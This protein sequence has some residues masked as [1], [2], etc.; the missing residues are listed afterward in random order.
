VAPPSPAAN[1]KK[2]HVSEPPQDSCETTQQPGFRP[3]H[4][5]F[6]LL[7]AY[8]QTFQEG[9]NPTDAV[10]AKRLGVRRET[11]SRWRRRNARLRAWLYEA[12]GERASELR[13]FVDRRV[14]QLAISGS[15]DHMKLFYQFVAKVG[16][17]VA[18]GEELSSDSQ[19]PSNAGVIINVLTP[20]PEMYA[21]QF[22][23]LPGPPT[24]G[25][26]A[27]PAALPPASNIPV[28]SVKVPV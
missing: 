21:P 23:Q 13:A 14:T 16:L 15:P 22:N 20:R 10:I 8:E 1:H 6:R 5:H 19:V 4:V 26:M 24:Q 18:A 12:L 9:I 2:S 17:P 11:I 27:S 3:K 28:L 7:D 25:P